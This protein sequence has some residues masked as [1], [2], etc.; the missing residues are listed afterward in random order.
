MVMCRGIG[1]ISNVIFLHQ[2]SKPH[3]PNHSDNLT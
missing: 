2:G 1:M 3:Q